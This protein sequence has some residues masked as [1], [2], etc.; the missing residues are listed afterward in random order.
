[1][2]HGLL[3]HQDHFLTYHWAG[4]LDTVLRARSGI[5]LSG[6][7]FCSARGF[8][9][10]NLYSTWLN[11]ASEPRTLLDRAKSSFTLSICSGSHMPRS[12]TPRT[13]LD[14]AKQDLL[15]LLDKHPCVPL[16]FS[17]LPAVR[18]GC[19][20]RIDVFKECIC[21]PL[22]FF[23]SLGA[24]KPVLWN[25]VAK[26]IQLAWIPKSQLPW[27]ALALWCISWK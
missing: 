14:R 9:T 1:M 19:V 26:K 10:G 6:R 15:I 7:K 27:R 2:F 5:R 11:T 24:W 25:D 3:D 12:H 17:R 18:Q 21:D 13:L 4:Q 8:A 20:S 16:C 23:S 22:V